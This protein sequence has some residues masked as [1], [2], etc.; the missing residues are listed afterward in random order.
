M[1][2]C[3][4]LFRNTGNNLVGFINDDNDNI[5]VFANRDVAIQ[6]AIDSPFLQ[7]FPHQIV[8]LEDL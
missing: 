4:I 2:E 5:A 8:E 7:H 1:I 6:F 3:I